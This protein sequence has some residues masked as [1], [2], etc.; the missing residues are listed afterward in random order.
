MKLI[1]FFLV[2]AKFLCSEVNL[3]PFEELLIDI[4]PKFKCFNEYKHNDLSKNNTNVLIK[5]KELDKFFVEKSIFCNKRGQCNL[6]QD[7]CD[8]YKGY[9]TSFTSVLKF[10]Q[11]DSRCNFKLSYNSI[12]VF[13][14][15]FLS[16]GSLHFYLGNYF[17]GMM[18]F[19]YFS[20]TLLLNVYCLYKIST[21]E[22]SRSI[23]DSIARSP[24]CVFG[25]FNQ[26]L[27]YIWYLFD[28]I[29]VMSNLYI[30]YAGN[31]TI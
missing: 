10:Q 19:G 1:C 30:D 21:K 2:I 6:D 31:E 22:S 11:S 27:C 24:M 3:I 14:S 7:N 15:C 9:M 20:S 16:F 29:F 13:L 8:C 26:I 12:A 18:Q 23:I 4:Y 25:C 28:I 17:L 5:D